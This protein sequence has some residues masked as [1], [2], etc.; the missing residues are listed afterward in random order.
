MAKADEQ[1]L[2]DFPSWLDE[3]MLIEFLQR[4]FKDYKA[5]KGFQ[6]VQTSGEGENF[7]C[8]VVRVKIIVGLNGQ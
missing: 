1:K 8:L 6:V 7:T 4:D 2:P 5:I 3:Q